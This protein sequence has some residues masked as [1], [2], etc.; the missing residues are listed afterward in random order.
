MLLIGGWEQWPPTPPESS[1]CSAVSVGFPALSCTESRGLAQVLP[2]GCGLGPGPGPP[3]QAAPPP[4]SLGAG[5]AGSEAAP[6]G[7]SVP[8][9]RPGI[10]QGLSFLPTLIL[11]AD[12]S[13]RGNPGDCPLGKQSESTNSPADA[14][15]NP[16][17]A[18][19]QLCLNLS[20]YMSAFV[21]WVMGSTA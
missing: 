7:P 11:P 5:S 15:P 17:F 4:H 21:K 16:S 8:A 13:R 20:E 10:P 6:Q 3:Q 18:T 2:K 9:P 19:H 1:F 12:L 14:C